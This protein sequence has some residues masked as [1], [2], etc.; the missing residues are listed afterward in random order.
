MTEL[1]KRM[2][3][4]GN[5]RRSSPSGALMITHVEDNS[6]NESGGEGAAADNDDETIAL[7]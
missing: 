5:A 1:V 4:A 3:R 7:R 6:E 2:S